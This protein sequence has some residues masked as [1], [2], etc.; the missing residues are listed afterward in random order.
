MKKQHTESYMGDMYLYTF[1]ALVDCGIYDFPLI[2]LTVTLMRV[3]RQHPLSLSHS[4]YALDLSQLSNKAICQSRRFPAIPICMRQHGNMA[5]PHTFVFRNSETIFHFEFSI[6]F[7]PILNYPHWILDRVYLSL[8]VPA[9]CSTW[10]LLSVSIRN[11]F[12]FDFFFINI[13]DSLPIRFIGYLSFGGSGLTSN[14]IIVFYVV[15]STSASIS[16]SPSWQLVR[17]LNILAVNIFQYVL[18]Q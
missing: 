2:I 1:V 15:F 4:L 3:L 18:S 12:S 9:K 17:Y 14:Y 13:P 5:Y 6:P 8:W 7:D 16:L 10:D 11:L